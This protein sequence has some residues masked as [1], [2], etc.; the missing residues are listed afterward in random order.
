MKAYLT[1]VFHEL[2][3]V[4]WLRVWLG[5][6][7]LTAALPCYSTQGVATESAPVPPKKCFDVCRGAS[8]GI[9]WKKFFTNV[10]V[11]STFLHRVL[12]IMEE[13]E[14]RIYPP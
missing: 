6:V 14:N 2:Q 3:A 10:T 12:D 4:D 11:D 9:S 7:G 13:R 8:D 1:G 5:Q